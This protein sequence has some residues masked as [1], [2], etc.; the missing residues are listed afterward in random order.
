[1]SKIDWSTFEDGHERVYGVFQSDPQHCDDPLCWGDATCI[2]VFPTRKLA[3]AFASLQERE[4]EF[5]SRM[6]EEQKVRPLKI[7]EEYAV[8]TP[9]RMWEVRSLAFNPKNTAEIFTS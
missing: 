6:A 5:K 7:Y 4:N 3:T 2:A 9:G 1:M 8:P